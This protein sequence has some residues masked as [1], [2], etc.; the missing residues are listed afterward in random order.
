MG[1]RG[2]VGDSQR[3][4]VQHV[5]AFLFKEVKQT[6]LISVLDIVKDSGIKENE[7]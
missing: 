4:V 3:L 7:L 6:W 1:G 5:C 2:G